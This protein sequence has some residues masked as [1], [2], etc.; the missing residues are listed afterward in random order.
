MKGRAAGPLL[1][2]G[3]TALVALVATSAPAQLPQRVEGVAAV[4]GAD[5]PVRTAAVILR[6]DVDLRARLLLAGREPEVRRGPV[7]PAVLRATLDQ[8]ITEALIARE[9]D[10][11]RAPAPTPV[12]IAA[13]RARLVA[14][15]GGPDRLREVLAVLGADMDEV[16]EVARRLAYVGAFLASTLEGALTVTEAQVQAAYD[17]DPERFGGRPLAEVRE[18]IRR[19]LRQSRREQELARWVDALRARTLVRRLAP[20]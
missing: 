9:A 12:D 16:E 1:G 13:Q 6:S 10:R 11:Q 7:P 5:A 14:Q 17:A 8:L 2:A 3:L 19:E 15:A 4:V 20:W 18:G